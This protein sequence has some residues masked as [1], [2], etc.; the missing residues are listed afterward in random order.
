M[1]AV[2]LN[3]CSLWLAVPQCSRT[4]RAWLEHHLANRVSDQPSDASPRPSGGLP[5]DLELSLAKINWDFSHVC[6][7]NPRSDIHERVGAAKIDVSE[8]WASTCFLLPGRR[9]RGLLRL[10]RLTL[11]LTR[12]LLRLLARYGQQHLALSFDPLARLFRLRWA[13]PRGLHAAA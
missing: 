11:R 5:Q 9:A 12:L 8:A 1:N 10:T 2:V 13:F 7:L 6:Q 4:C 3:G